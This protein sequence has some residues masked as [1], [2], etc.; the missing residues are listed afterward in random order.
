M[1]TETN[2]VFYKLKKATNLYNH[3]AQCFHI[4]IIQL[5][6]PHGKQYSGAFYAYSRYLSQTCHKNFIDKLL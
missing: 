4:Y 1:K 6:F 3:V 5:T 2:Y